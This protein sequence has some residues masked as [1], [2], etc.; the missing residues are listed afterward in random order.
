MPV[1][2]N[3]CRCLTLK[4]GTIVTG[5]L[6]IIIALTTLI[7]I[8]VV[9]MKMKTIVADHLSSETVKIIVAINLAMTILISTLLIIGTIKK[10]RWLMAPWVILAII[11]VIGLAV[12]VIYTSV[13]FYINNQPLNGTIWL[14]IG[15]LG[16]AI[17]TYLWFVVFSYFQ[18]IKEEK[19]GRSPYFRPI[20]P[21]QR[22]KA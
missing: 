15:L 4:T 2:K 22:G 1:L 7:T 14:I 3:C 18:L 21:Y 12:S 20:Y 13:E 11:L 10:N 5:V 6:A 16:C 9:K 8:L 19:E 17:S